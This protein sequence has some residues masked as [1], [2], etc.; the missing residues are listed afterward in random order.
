MEEII[1]YNSK[2]EKAVCLVEWWLISEGL[3]E[4]L[5]YAQVLLIGGNGMRR[6]IFF[7]LW[8]RLPPLFH[9]VLV[10]A[11]AVESNIWS[12][13]AVENMDFPGCI[14]AER[15]AMTSETHKRDTKSARKARFPSNLN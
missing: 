10:R 1:W 8:S 12:W 7:V 9:E 2:W 14:R 4:L 15:I 3:L 6:W 13:I 11:L 5:E